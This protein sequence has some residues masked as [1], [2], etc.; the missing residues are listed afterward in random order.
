MQTDGWVTVGCGRN[1]MPLSS[2]VIAVLVLPEA[3][4]MGKGGGAEGGGTAMPA[5]GMLIMGSAATVTHA[6]NARKGK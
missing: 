1:T 6:N 3:P 5:R 2:V 4:G